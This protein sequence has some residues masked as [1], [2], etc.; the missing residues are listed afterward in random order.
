MDEP[1]DY[2]AKAKR[3]KVPEFAQLYVLVDIA[4]SLRVLKDYITAPPIRFVLGK[5]EA[6]RIAWEAVDR[7]KK[8]DVR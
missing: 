4:E 3:T 2:L 5:E 8:G 7:L 1:I 6:D